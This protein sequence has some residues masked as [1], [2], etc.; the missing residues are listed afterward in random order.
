M[1]PFFALDTATDHLA[2]AIGDLDTPGAVVAAVDLP[3]PRAANTVIALETERL[4][5]VAGI[6]SR[7]LRAVACGRGPGSFTGVRI[8]VSAA[9]GLAHGLGIPLGGFGTLDA[10]ARRVDTDGLVGVV[11]DAMRGEVYPALFRVHAGVVERLSEDRV[12]APDE[13]AALWASLGE[14]VTLTGNALIK[15]GETFSRLLGAHIRLAPDRLRSPDGA[16]LIAAAWAE[17]G[18]LG[19]SELAAIPADA[20]DRAHATRLLPVYTRLSDAEEAERR[21]ASGAV[22]PPGGVAGPGPTRAS[23]S[24]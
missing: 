23:E 6:T 18:P 15:H 22:V 10:V 9:K 13:V 24:R 5:A 14:T 20:V 8:G 7:D 1:R 21:A 12:C 17:P 16:S 19:V 3:A 11:G 4:L 2:L